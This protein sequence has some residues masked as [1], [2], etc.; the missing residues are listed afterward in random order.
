MSR[1]LKN[2]EKYADCTFCVEDKK[3]YSHKLILSLAS[4]VFEAMFYGYFE[5][6]S[7]IEISDITAITFNLMLEFIY[8]DQITGLTNDGTSQHSLIDRYSIETYIELFYC[9]EKYLL[10]DLR[11]KS[12]RAIS[13]GLDNSNIL[14]VIE[15]AFN[16]NIEAITEMCIRHLHLLSIT[17]IHQFK[18]LIHRPNCH[19]SKECLLF[20]VDQYRN[21]FDAEQIESFIIE[22]VEQWYAKENSNQQ[23]SKNFQEILDELRDGNDSRTVKLMDK[24]PIVYRADREHWIPF[25]RKKYGSSGKLKLNDNRI[26]SIHLKTNQTVLIKSLI[27]NTRLNTLSSLFGSHVGDRQN[28]R[29]SPFHSPPKRTYDEEIQITI[30]SS[31]TNDLI[32][33][34]TFQKKHLEF[35]SKVFLT[36]KK[37][38]SLF[39]YDAVTIEFEWSDKMNIDN[40]E[41]PCNTY[42]SNEWI[43]DEVHLDF[44]DGEEATVDCFL[45]GIEYAQIF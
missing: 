45:D 44:R 41:Y 29:F 13:N 12:L 19:I 1:L 36:F 5:N 23:N 25:F 10:N 15:F 11:E 16:N 31:K 26:H 17:N 24:F 9:A 2:G 21:Y 40:L 4:P 28:F 18:Q 22:F 43:N 7:I 38:I 39:N 30:R 34:E 35:N 32:R 42:I 6:E 20:L 8:T 27:L 33:I 14:Q 37:P 3:I